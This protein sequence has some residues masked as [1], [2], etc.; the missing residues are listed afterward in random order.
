MRY[1]VLGGAGFI[2]SHVTETLLSGGHEVTVVDRPNAANLEYVRQRGA[3]VVPGDVLDAGDMQRTLSACEVVLHLASSTLPQQS[4][5]SPMADVQRNLLGALRILEA[6]RLAGV[7]RIVFASSGGT[8]YGNARKVPIDEAHPTE[9]IS[10]Y[11]ICKLAI[12]KYLH[13]YWVLHRLDY[14]VLRM[15]NVYGERQATNRLQ[16]IVGTALQKALEGGQLTVWGDGSATRDYVHALDVARAFESAARAVGEERIFNIGSGQGH[17]VIDIV[18]MVEE[19]TG[20]PVPLAFLSGRAGDVRANVLDISR[21][22]IHL[23]WEPRI[24][25][26]EGIARVYEW[27]RGQASAGQ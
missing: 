14:R 9:P 3:M 13:L 24:G 19:V 10:S 23:D 11:G 16:G 12:E 25:L 20:R 8:V 27:L 18:R 7:K 15:A 22:R 1:A 17:S 2:G 6:A 4:N 21:A 26:R 5:D